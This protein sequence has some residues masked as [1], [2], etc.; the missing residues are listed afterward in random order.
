MIDSAFWCYVHADDHNDQGR[1]LQLAWDI[2]NEFAAITA[3][4]LD[5]TVDR[6]ASCWGTTGASCSTMRSASPRS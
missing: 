6:K 1:I 3:D 5:M 4:L 2:Q